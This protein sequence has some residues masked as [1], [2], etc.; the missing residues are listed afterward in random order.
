M[1]FG[2]KDGVI[3]YSQRRKRPRFSLAFYFFNSS[4]I[5]LHICALW[6][7]TPKKGLHVPTKG[8]LLLVLSKNI[9]YVYIAKCLRY[10]DADGGGRF[11]PFLHVALFKQKQIGTYIIMLFFCSCC[12]YFPFFG[13]GFYIRPCILCSLLVAQN[14]V[15]LYAWLCLVLIPVSITDWFYVTVTLPYTFRESH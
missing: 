1:S 5:Y 3:I 12:T 9:S 10:D 14:D 11:R 8:M 4:A 2:D 15:H 7:K 6:A 13:G